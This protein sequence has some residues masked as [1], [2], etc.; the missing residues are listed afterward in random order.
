MEPRQ[1]LYNTL[2]EDLGDFVEESLVPDEEWERDEQDAWHRCATF[3]KDHCFQ[4]QLVAGQEVRVLKVMKGGSYGKGTSLKHTS[5]VDLILFLSCFSSFQDQ[6]DLRKEIIDFIKKKVE[7]CSQSLAYS[8]SVIPYWG[9]NPRS[10][11][12]QVQAKKNSNVIKVDVLPAFDVLG[13]ASPDSNL[14]QEIFEK[15]INFEGSPGEFSS[16]FTVLHR[17]FVRTRPV[18]VKN[19]LRLVKHWWY[20]QHKKYKRVKVALPPKYALELLTI[21][22]WETGTDESENFD[23]A[24]GFKAVMKLV[25]DYNNICI[26]WTKYYNF[27]NEA[28]SIF[29]KEKLKEERPVILDPADPTNNLGRG[30]SWDVM[31][32]EA[33]YTLQQDCCSTVDP[34]PVRAA[35][36]VQVKVEVPGNW[37]LML[38]VDPYRP[39]WKMKKSIEEM[40]HPSGQQRLS[41]QEP[42]EERKE[43]S[44]FK[45]LA[46]YGIFARVT[47][48]VLVTEPGEIQVFVKDSSGRSKPYAVYPDDS[49]S[50]LKEKIEEAG[51][52]PAEDQILKFPGHKVRYSSNLSELQVQ[53]GDTFR[54]FRIGTSNLS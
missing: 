3:L 31:A 25:R 8:I 36:D 2:P 9:R 32:K 39:I 4:G 29:I 10:L 53:D 12:I 26:Y 6:A 28:V 1:D 11:A 42:G 21:Y 19:L 45:T 52:P 27:Q 24:E 34:W 48:S 7:H 17:H 13:N 54:L 15:L 30:K 20:L 22:A 43:L 46:D 16:S 40:W 37:V 47:V 50:D 41:F 33:A 49:I 5:D 23:L 51:G 38:M 44:N 14:P 35:R 18:K